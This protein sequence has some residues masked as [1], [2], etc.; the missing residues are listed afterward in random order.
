MSCLSQAVQSPFQPCPMM[1]SNRR[2]VQSWI[3]TL[4]FRHVPVRLRTY[5]VT[6]SLSTVLQ[7]V[8]PVLR[9]IVIHYK[10]ARFKSVNFWYLSVKKW[11]ISVNFNMDYQQTGYR[12]RTSISTSYQVWQIPSFWIIV[13]NIDVL[14]RWYRRKTSI[15][16]F[17]WW[18]YR[19]K[20]SI[21]G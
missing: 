9:H 3:D 17:L 20:T 14:W 12:R 1:L 21:S 13:P 2:K 19:T 10:G 18:L 11:Y 7:R 6:L 16:T 4:S 8:T 5:P 15:S